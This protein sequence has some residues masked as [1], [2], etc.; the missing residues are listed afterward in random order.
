L[1]WNIL[2][3]FTDFKSIVNSLAPGVPVITLGGFVTPNVR[4]VEGD[5]YGQIYGNAYLRD[6]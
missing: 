1:N 6:P 2:V 4:L 3:S 5:E